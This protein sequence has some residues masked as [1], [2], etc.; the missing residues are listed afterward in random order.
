M[1]KHHVL[2]FCLVETVLGTMGI[3][4]SQIGLREVILPKPSCTAVCLTALQK[5]GI[6]HETAQAFFSDLPQRFESYFEGNCVD[7]PD[8]LDLSN[9]SDF[10]KSVWETTR[11]IPYGE[12][13]SY[14]WVAGR[15]GH[16][17]ASRA[18]GQA[19]GKNPLPIVV[20]CHRVI[21]GDGNIGGFSGGIGIKKYLLQMENGTSMT[22]N[23]DSM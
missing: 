6:A 16:D 14:S 18:V 19:L 12:T 3:I 9:A 20:P 5:Y 15:S 21:A 8:V 23:R 11:S 22:V 4:M 10:Q 17:Q 2:Y 1:E 7:F 13:R